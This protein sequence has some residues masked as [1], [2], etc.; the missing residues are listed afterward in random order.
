MAFGTVT[1]F[2][3][4]TKHLIPMPNTYY[5]PK[6]QFEK[7]RK[8]AEIAEIHEVCFVV[9]GRGSRI[10]RLVEVPNR[11]SD[12]VFHHVIMEADFQRV[13]KR[14][15]L[16]HLKCLGFLHT[17]AVAEAIPSRGDIVGYAKGTLMFIYSDS[18]R[19]RAY[20]LDDSRRGYIEKQVVVVK[21]GVRLVKGRLGRRARP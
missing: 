6:R 13:R 19:L 4:G 2:P 9:F 10:V 7:L 18:D 21:E 17:H 12:T 16:M 14:R 11:A 20:R 3:T 1:Y 15:S 5:I 8:R